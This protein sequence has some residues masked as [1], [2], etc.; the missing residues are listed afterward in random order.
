MAGAAF[1]PDLTQTFTEAAEA[2]AGIAGILNAFKVVELQKD[3]Y[4]LYKQQRDFY[5]NTFHTGVEAPLAAD[6]YS[7][8]PYYLDYVGR[9]SSA[10]AEDGPFNKDVT[11]TLGWWGRHASIYSAD[12]D[13]AMQIELLAEE[14]KIRSDWT[15]Y[16]LRFE[17]HYFDVVND[18]RWNKRITVHNIGI[19]QGTAIAAAL[20]SS[21]GEFTGH[22]HNFGDQLATYGNGIAK[23]V[24][25]RRG[26][27]DTSDD[28]NA[29]G[30]LPSTQGSQSVNA[31]KAIP[32]TSDKV[33][34][35]G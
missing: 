3:Y 26:L 29:A 32:Y 24:G 21:L 30:Y 14:A 6:T 12:T 4:N 5:Y 1:V 28:F 9:V 31:Y 8:L 17:E 18:I 15:N 34:M 23:Y 2:A 35:Y 27:S 33:G 11:D 19:K 20:D 22:L 25:Y 13:P 16:L 10:Y 7:D